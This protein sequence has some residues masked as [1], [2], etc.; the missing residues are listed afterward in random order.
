[1]GPRVAPVRVVLIR[2]AHPGGGY[3]EDHD[4]GLDDVGLRQAAAMTAAVAP[5]GPRPVYVSPLRRTRETA[6]VLERR[7]A[8]E[9]TVEPRVGEIPSPFESLEERAVWLR[10]V[11]PSTWANQPAELV[12]WRGSLLAALRELSHDTI[13]VTHFVAINAVVGAAT[14]DDRITSC[15]PDYCSQTVLDVDADGFRLIEM[16]AQ[17]STRIR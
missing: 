7:W 14:G 6:A 1:M 10:E 4:P 5:L 13:V 2:H 11:L 3:G 9:A 8:T 16:G 17:A 12:Q 15:M